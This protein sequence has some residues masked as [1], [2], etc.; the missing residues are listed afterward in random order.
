MCDIIYFELNNWTAG[1]DYPDEEPFIS[2]CGNDMD[3]KFSNEEWV[4][5]NKLA[6]VQEIIDMSVNWCISAPKEWVLENCPKLLEGNAVNPYNGFLR[7][8]DKNGKV[9]GNL[10]TEFLEWSEG[11]IGIHCLQYDAILDN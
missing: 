4:V 10:G 3:L 2:W 6:V 8:P 11:N 7:F 9:Y 1:D 5:K